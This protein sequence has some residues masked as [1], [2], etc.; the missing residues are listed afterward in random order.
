LFSY[1]TIL[2]AVAFRFLRALYCPSQ[3]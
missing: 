2:K 1:L 3:D